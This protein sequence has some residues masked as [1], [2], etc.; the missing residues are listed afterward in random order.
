MHPVAHRFFV[1]AQGKSIPGYGHPPRDPAY[2]RITRSRRK[3]NWH[4]G[5]GKSIG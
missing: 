3:K 4:T 5:L 1:H 2:V